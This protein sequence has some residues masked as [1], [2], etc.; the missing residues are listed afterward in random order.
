MK[1]KNLR[2]GL[3]VFALFAMQFSAFAE[4]SVI[5]KAKI[6]E[7]N[8]LIKQKGAHWVAKENWVSRLSK[9][10]IKRMLGSN[11]MPTN[12]LDF[13]SAK[14]IGT[15]SVDWR[16][17]G[18]I[19]W[20]G[21]VMNQGNCGS[22]VAFASIATLE[23]QISINSGLPWVRPSFSPQ[24]LFAC[25]GMGCEG[26]WTGSGAARFLKGTG[27]VDAACAPYTMGSTGVDVQCSQASCSDAASRTFK[28][29]GSTTPS[30]GIFS[31]NVDKVKKALESGPLLTTLTVYEDFLTYS[32][33]IYKTVGG[34]ALG[35][36]AVSL[37]GYDDTKRAWL[38]R[39]S[40]G[41]DWGDKGFIWFSYDD[42][43]GI[44]SSTWQFQV[45]S[46]KAYLTIESPSENDYVSGQYQVK[47]GTNS[48]DNLQVS[49]RKVGSKDVVTLSCTKNGT[50]S[51]VSVLDT[52]ALTDGRYEMS[53][54]IGSTSTFT[55]VRSFYVVNHLP[56]NMSIK[57]SGDG[58]DLTKPLKDRIVFN[59]STT[60]SPVP[61]HN[62][63]F[64]V[65]KN[66]QVVA[67]RTT[68]L[69]LNEMKLGFRTNSL[70]DGE[71]DILFHGEL[72][73]AGKLYTVDSPVM[74]VI[75]KQ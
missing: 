63:S 5:T 50:D 65:R 22:C 58:V 39:N 38:V 48:S 33:G 13:E 69:V 14:G 12:T 4:D 60:S 10:E 26:G 52:T 45:P 19:N 70:P 37:I 35:G 51:C 72:P 21:P 6:Q 55:Q 7:I 46:E 28:I 36:H 74:H 61:F 24:Q 8:Q 75:F 18:G 25:G 3:V 40:W 2:T 27:V 53:T 62:I 11:E 68:D 71:Y 1:T 54:S 17:K 9:S 64:Q 29:T 32:G 15:T 67:Q 23:A 20:L 44:A 56:T 59:V 43:S 30:S 47:A 31:S 42:T 34:S 16:N 49:V 66:G 41:P 73:A 57:F